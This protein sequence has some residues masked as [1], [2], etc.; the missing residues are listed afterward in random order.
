MF[1]VIICM[2]NDISFVQT[3]SLAVF[4]TLSG[5]ELIESIL[6]QTF[7]ENYQWRY[8]R[9]HRGLVRLSARSR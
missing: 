1:M 4:K 6:L 3:T 5:C 9:H 2:A 8:R 7:T